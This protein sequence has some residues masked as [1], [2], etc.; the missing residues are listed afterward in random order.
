MRIQYF[1][2]LLLANSSHADDVSDALA[3]SSFA[4]LVTIYAGNQI[5]YKGGELSNCGSGY[6]AYASA[7]QVFVNNIE[8][9]EGYPIEFRAGS[10]LALGGTYLV[11][12]NEVATEASY[13]GPIG[14]E[15]R[16]RRC[17]EGGISLVPILVDTP[18]I[19]FEAVF[20]EWRID[21]E[22]GSIDGVGYLN[23]FLASKELRN[24]FRTSRDDDRMSLEP[25]SMEI[26][27]FFGL[28]KPDAYVSEAVLK[29]VA[30]DACDLRKKSS[31]SEND[32]QIASCKR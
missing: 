10:M 20:Q 13:A 32:L 3:Q 27:Q 28:T 29:L 18:T 12:L 30:D 24:F 22:P 15:V 4:G 16:S 5:P 9:T 23:Y 8:W 11:F 25:I 2:L 21:E 6:V 19:G 17:M 31:E 26:R 14:R 7:R 1:V